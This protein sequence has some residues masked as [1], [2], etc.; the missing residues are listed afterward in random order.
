MSRR[1]D[2]GEYTCTGGYILAVDA[3][4]T[5]PPYDEERAMPPVSLF[6]SEQTEATQ[7][8]AANAERQ[9]VV[10]LATWS[11]NMEVSV[12]RR[13]VELPQCNGAPITKGSVVREMANIQTAVDYQLQLLVLPPG[14]RVNNIQYGQSQIC[15]GFYH[16]TMPRDCN[17]AAK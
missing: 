10:D 4:L 15:E 3:A 9:F 14:L 6:R 12:L 1:G 5:D 13:W 17:A 2:C 8:G 7:R 11:A 16:L